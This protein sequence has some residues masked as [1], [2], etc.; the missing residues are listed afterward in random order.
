MEPTHASSR[1]Q[2]AASRLHLRE[3]QVVLVVLVECYG[4]LEVAAASLW[5]GGYCSVGI[6]EAVLGFLS[7]QDEDLI[8]AYPH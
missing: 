2:V 4:L 1:W 5:C 3:V 6:M 8:D 7:R